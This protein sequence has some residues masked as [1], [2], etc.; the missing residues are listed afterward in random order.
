VEQ[1]VGALGVAVGECARERELVLCDVAGAA[2]F[3][4]GGEPFSR[5]SRRGVG[6][7]A[8]HG[9]EGRRAEVDRHVAAVSG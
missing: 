4:G 8:H 1:R 5:E 2:D 3:A 9:E 7:A 6:V